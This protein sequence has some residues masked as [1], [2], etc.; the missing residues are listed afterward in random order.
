MKTLPP[1]LK[2]RI[3]E[4]EKLMKLLRDAHEAHGDFTARSAEET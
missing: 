3:R 4:E 2:A 1:K